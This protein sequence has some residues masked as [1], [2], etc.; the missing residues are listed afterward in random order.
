MQEGDD[1]IDDLI[2]GAPRR[3]DG[4]GESY[5][6]FGSDTGFGPTL[7]LDS[8]DGTNGFRLGGIDAF[9]FNGGFDDRSDRV[10]PLAELM[11]QGY[12]DAYHQFVEPVVGASGDR[13]GQTTA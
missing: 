2:V 3:A 4:A 9:D 1:G 8:L 7:A 5:L 11:T 6:V 13:V 12:E 10:Q